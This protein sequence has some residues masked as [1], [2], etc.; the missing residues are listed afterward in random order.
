MNDFLERLRKIKKQGLMYKFWLFVLL[1]TL[2]IMPIMLYRDGE[3]FLVV[4]L[5]DLFLAV[6][7]VLLVYTIPNNNK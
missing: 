7:G 4:F 1:L 2:I 5:A 6:I 3:P